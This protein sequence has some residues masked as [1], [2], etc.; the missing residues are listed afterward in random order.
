MKRPL[1]RALATWLP[2]DDGAAAERA[3][4]WY[5][6]GLGYRILGRN[7]RAGG[8][9]LDLVATEGDTLCFIEVKARSSD[10]FGR[11]VEAVGRDKQRRLV[12]A[13]RGYLA[14]H[15]WPGPCRIDVIGVEPAPG[16]RHRFEL[17]KNAFEA[18]D[19]G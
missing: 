2:G 1:W 12:R 18:D 4:E 15:P 5:L 10:H 8:G 11:A 6:R 13:A 7:V 3:A 14:R 19:G 16:G 9:E 17:L